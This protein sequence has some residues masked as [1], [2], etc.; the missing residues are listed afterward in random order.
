[1]L[2]LIK[3]LPKI[4]ESHSNLLIRGEIGTGREEL[5][6]LIHQMSPRRNNE[7]VSIP[8]ADDQLENKLF[9][10]IRNANRDS[11]NGQK[12]LFEIANGGT[13][14]IDQIADIPLPLQ[15]KLFLALKS[16]L[17]RR[18]GGKDELKFDVRIICTSGK[19]LSD[20]VSNGYVREDFFYNL[21]LLGIDLPPLRERQED[22]P[23]LIRLMLKKKAP[24]KIISEAAIRI[25]ISQQWRGNLR[26]I[27]SVIERIVLF[28]D[29][30]VITPADLPYKIIEEDVPSQIF[31]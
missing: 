25:L 31:P 3:T 2:Q 26:E 8:C 19:D 14:F 20:A 5:A 7:F 24:D 10:Y 29:N 18:I 4:A 22:L 17:L 21:N 27:E 12:G 11:N 9:G 28:S 16:G 23:S 13:I 30:E 15:L 6:K 1:M